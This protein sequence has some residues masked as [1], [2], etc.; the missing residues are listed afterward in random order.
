MTEALL[1][2]G[3]ASAKAIMPRSPLMAFHRPVLIW[4]GWIVKQPAAT[5]WV[6]HNGG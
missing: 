4:A 3:T 6:N 1:K 2:S 5:G